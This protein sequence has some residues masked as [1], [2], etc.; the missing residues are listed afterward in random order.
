MDKIGK[1]II[2][3]VGPYLQTAQFQ[4]PMTG[5]ASSSFCKSLIAMP[6]DSKPHLFQFEFNGAPE[7][8]NKD[9]P[10][11]SLGSGQP[12]ADPFLA[13][14]RRLLWSNHEPSLSEGRL[15]AV[16][17]I[18]HVRRTNPGGVGGSIQLA[19]LESVSNKMPMVN[20]ASPQDVEE[21]LQ[22]VSLAEQA[23]VRELIGKGDVNQG[24]GLP[25]PPK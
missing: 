6:V 20:I 14:L 10:F 8:C 9:T 25:P 23:L 13:F 15:A 22:K 4:Q 19:T 17:T 3:L 5:G 24:T 18:D 21:H 2:Q 7:R 16:W 1:D 11:V 12:I